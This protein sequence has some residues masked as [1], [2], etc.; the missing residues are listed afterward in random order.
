MSRTLR[1]VVVL[2][3]ATVLSTRLPLNLVV[4]LVAALAMNDLSLADIPSILVASLCLDHISLLPLGF[5]ILPLIALVACLQILK[6]QI[7]VQG[8]GSRFLWALTG[9]FFFDLAWLGLLA[10]R[11]ET[12]LYIWRVVVWGGV[13][14]LFE[15]GMAA[16]LAAPL[17]RA[18]TVTLAELRR[19]RSI[20][21]P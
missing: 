8:G 15:A 19:P 3:V 2:I 21:V 14:G 17:A 10:L 20:V 5:S 18:L 11:G 1:M 6:S 16:A 4:V 7:Y 13:R 9:I 12:S